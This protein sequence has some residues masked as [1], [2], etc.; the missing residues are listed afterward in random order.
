[1][2]LYVYRPEVYDEN[3]RP[4]EVDIGILKG[5]SG[6]IGVVPCAWEGSYYRFGEQVPERMKDE[7]PKTIRRVR[8]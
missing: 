3:M 2:I 1:V 6:Q 4:G 5:R 8:E 7:R